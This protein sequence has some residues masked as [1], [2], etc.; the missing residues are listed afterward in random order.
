MAYVYRHIRTDKNE[1][2]YIGVGLGEDERFSRAYSDKNRN[3]HWQR[4][5][6]KT[7]YKVEIV[8][9]GLTDEEAFAKEIEFIHLYGKRSE[10]GTLCNIA[11]GGQGGCL[12]EEVNKLRSLA[13]IGHKLSEETKDKIRNKAKGRKI[14]QDTK[15]KMSESHKQRKTGHWLKSNGHHN[16]NA[17][18]VYQY[19]TNNNFIR[20]WECAAYAV[21]EL[22]ICKSC[23]SA[24]LAGR[25]KT[26][27]GFVWKLNSLLIL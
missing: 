12:G 13:L 17:K 21:K 5:V 1:P 15:H 10:G 23:I 16:G 3:P 6:N 9:D 14:L 2:F 27:G 4:I 7:S 26:A 18:K 22:K 8:I 20:E 25:Q 24:V 11:N 19:D